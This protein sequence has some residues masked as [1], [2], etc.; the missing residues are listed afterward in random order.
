ME[1]FAKR[2][3][4]AAVVLLRL[5]AGE[6]V[7]PAL[8][9]SP[10]PTTRSYIIDRI[11]NLGVDPE[12]VWNRLNVESDPSARAALILSLGHYPPDVFAPKDPVSRRAAVLDIYRNDVDP[13]V[14]G[15]AYGL[16]PY[17]RLSIA[18]S[19]EA[20]KRACDRIEEACRALR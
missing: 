19:M 5:G 15:A 12:I 14:H 8:R 18:T 3:G 11:A 1:A 17:F 6:R 10:D 9:H 16:S 7:W 2:Q 20:I 4:N 13:A